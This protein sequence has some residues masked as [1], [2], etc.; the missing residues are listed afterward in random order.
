MSL[1]VI[2]NNNFVFVLYTGNKKAIR[3]RLNRYAIC[4]PRP[5]LAVTRTPNLFSISIYL[6][7][8]FITNTQSPLCKNADTVYTC[9]IQVLRRPVTAKLLERREAR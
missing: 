1:L 6:H 3:L 2:G 7:T 8:V 9:S 5:S 4:T